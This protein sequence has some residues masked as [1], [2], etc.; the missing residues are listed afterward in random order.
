MQKFYRLTKFIK[1]PILVDGREFSCS[2]EVVKVASP[3]RKVG[4]VKVSEPRVIASVI[5]RYCLKLPDNNNPDV[6]IFTARVT[7]KFLFL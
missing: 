6:I 1:L 5:F 3:S 7:H 2:D 4:F